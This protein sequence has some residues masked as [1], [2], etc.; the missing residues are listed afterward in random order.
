MHESRDCSSEPAKT[1]AIESRLTSLLPNRVHGIPIAVRLLPRNDVIQLR[2][3]FGSHPAH[4]IAEK[5]EN[6]S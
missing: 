4:R 2:E 3:C 6:I 5:K 1:Y